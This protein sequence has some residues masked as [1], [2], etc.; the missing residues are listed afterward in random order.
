MQDQLVPGDGVVSGHGKVD[1]RQVYAFAQDFTVFAD[2]SPRPTPEDLQGDG[3]GPAHG[4][5][6]R[7]PE[8]LG[9]ARIQEGVMSLGGYATSSS[10][11]RWRRRRAADLGHH[12]PCAG[13]AVYSPAI[14]RL[15]R[16]GEGDEL[17]VRHRP[18]RHQDVTHEDVTRKTSAGHDAQRAERRGALRRRERPRVPRADPRAARLP[19]RQQPGRRATGGHGG[20]ADREDESLDTLV[21]ASPYS[22]TTCSI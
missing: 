3:P 12:G 6:H 15:Q 4:R 10:A 18:G 19:A 2:R 20:P 17:H 21:P 5:A 11:T 13:G 8:R 22:R 7:G 16:H 9:R 1:G 14:T